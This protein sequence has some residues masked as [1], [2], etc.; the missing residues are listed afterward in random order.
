MK[1]DKVGIFVMIMK[2]LLAINCQRILSL[3][4]DILTDFFANKVICSDGDCY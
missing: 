4:V 2:L 3:N 1:G